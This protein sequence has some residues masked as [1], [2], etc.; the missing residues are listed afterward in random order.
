MIPQE[1]ITGARMLIRHA[2]NGLWD[3]TLT[4]EGIIR[5]L[6]EAYGELGSPWTPPAKQTPGPFWQVVADFLLR[7]K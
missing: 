4:E 3:G 6:R 1:N 5:A 2:L 7:R